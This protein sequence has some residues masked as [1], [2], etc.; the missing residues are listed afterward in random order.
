MT[1]M[2][3][4]RIDDLQF[5]GLKIIQN[6]QYFCFGMDAVLLAHFA[7]IKKSERA[8]DLGTGTGILPLLLWGRYEFKHMTGLEIQP[9]IAEMAARSVKLNNLETQITII[10]Q[11]LRDYGFGAQAGTMDAV[12]SNPPYKK[13]GSGITSLGDAQALSRHEITCCLEDVIACASRL[14]RSQGRF[15]TINQSDRFIELIQLMRRYKIEPKRFRLIQS[16]ADKP[17]NLVLA[18]GIKNARP[19]ASFEPTLIVYNSD[20]SPT[21][22]LDKIYHRI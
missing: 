21:L 2:P 14:L 20:G 15:Y 13:A 12:I 7:R 6:P 9:A 8:A 19:H 3:N 1:L 22:E 18:E 10:N 4:E 11:D 16:K 17:P 5:R